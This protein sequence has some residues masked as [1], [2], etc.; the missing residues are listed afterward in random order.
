MN[1][2]CCRCCPKYGGTTDLTDCQIRNVDYPMRCEES[3]MIWISVENGLP[4]MGEKVILF[5]NGV[6]QEETYT[7]DHGDE[8]GAKFFWSRDGLDE[9]PPVK[10]TDKWMSLP[11]PP[12]DKHP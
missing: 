9:C 6:V 12:A 1:S 3:E 2:D 5:A 4:A 11:N 8:V 10:D 7:V